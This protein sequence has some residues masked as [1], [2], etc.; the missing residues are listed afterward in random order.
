MFPY[1]H[2]L[3]RTIGMYGLFMVLGFLLAGYLSIRYYKSI[4]QPAEDIFIVGACGIGGAMLLGNLLYVI[5]TYPAEVIVAYIKAGNLSIFGS[6]IVFYGGLIGGILGATIGVCVAKGKWGL[7]SEAIV[8]YVPLGHGLG[9]IGCLMA[10]CCYGMEYEGSFAVHYGK[11]LFGLDPQQGYFP[12]QPLEA[13]LNWIICAVLILLRRRNKTKNYLLPAYL[14]MYAVV[15]FGLEFLRGDLHRG[16]YL[17]LSLSQWISCGLL[18][19]GAGWIW[20]K[21][22]KLQ[23][24]VCL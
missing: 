8:P 15:R 7:L 13:V 18:L 10:G 12:I 20:L 11:S 16:I 22:R 21:R 5:V 19:W 2:I 9:R 6:G 23:N 3:G 17:G 24:K 4:G 14:C 1:I